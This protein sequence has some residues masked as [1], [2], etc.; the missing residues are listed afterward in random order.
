MLMIVVSSSSGQMPPVNT[1]S[2]GDGRITCAPS[3]VCSA[4]RCSSTLSGA[5]MSSLI[6]MAS[7]A[8]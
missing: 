1:T 7:F 8:R 5:G 6:S 2:R 4:S 3:S